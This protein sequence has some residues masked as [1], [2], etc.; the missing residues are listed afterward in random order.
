[1]NGQMGEMHNAVRLEA[2]GLMT[3]GI[4]HDLGNM[5]QQMQSAVRL[6][7]R[8]PQVKAS[9]GLEPI[10]AGATM[11]MEQAGALIHQLL[12]FA[13]NDR[14]MQELVD[15]PLCLAR[16]EPLLRWCCG[17]DVELKMVIAVNL[18][19]VLC[20][21]RSF[22]NAVLNLVLNARDA[23]SAGGRIVVCGRTR[24]DPIIGDCV[25]LSVADSGAGMEPAIAVRA[26]EPFFT[27]KVGGNGLG[28]PMVKRFAQECG[29]YA[30]I[31]SEPGE[32]TLVGLHLPVTGVE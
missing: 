15:L 3:A 16:L 8:H 1:M 5:V 10:L 18:P 6:I 7:A 32:G 14:G 23:V 30:T 28:L 20:S 2:L 19:R 9:E 26:F 22:E 25:S 29:G 27:T 11:S 17:N 13:R 12:A 24:I 31:E 4:V 21:R